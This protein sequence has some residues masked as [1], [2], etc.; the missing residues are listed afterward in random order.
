MTN[1]SADPHGRHATT[2]WQIPLPAWKEVSVRVWNQSWLDNIGLVAAGVAFYGFLALVPLLGVLVLTYGMF[3][4]PATVIDHVTTM[5]RFLP[6]DVVML[7]GQLLMNAVRASQQTSGLGIL[8]ALGVALYA[9]SNGAGAVMSSL[10]I[11]YEEKEKRSLLRFYGIAIV[12]TV[13]ATLIALVALAAMAAVGELER[14]LP[15][16]TPAILIAGKVGLYFGMA[17]LAAGIAAM[18]YRFG[19]SRE[20]ARWH[21]LTPGSIFTAIVWLLLAI[22]FSF[23][24]TRLTDYSATYGSIAAIVMLLTWMYLSA[25]AFLFGAE[26]NAELEH[27]TKK[28][29]TTGQPEPLGERGAWVADHVASVKDEGLTDDGPSMAEAG[30]PPPDD[31]K[32]SSGRGK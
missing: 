4:Q 2:P 32:A 14:I 1:K 19:P 22:G 16:A 17:L 13:G 9:G 26:L 29:S 10:N 3:T 20:D 28:D 11:A 27:Q 18:L 6:P 25:Y 24:V 30:P 31:K 23:Y 12:I 21:W 5:V 15:K 8:A 7:I